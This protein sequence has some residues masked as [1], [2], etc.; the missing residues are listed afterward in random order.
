VT[1]YSY[2]PKDE[3]DVAED[4]FSTGGQIALI[5]TMQA[6]NSAR[7]TV[8]GSVEMLENTWFEAIVKGPEDKKA[9]KTVNREFAAQ[10]T[11]WTFNEV[12]LV[13][14]GK[15]DHF[16]ASENSGKSKNTNL[17]KVGYLN[18]HIYRVKNDVVCYLVTEDCQVKTNNPRPLALSSPNTRM[19][20]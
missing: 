19:T 3:A 2:N 7:F 20:A 1:A 5:S 15:V 9:V 13:K 10:V 12:G 8:L 16:L 17:T 6:R 11:E 4:P 14:V 18:P